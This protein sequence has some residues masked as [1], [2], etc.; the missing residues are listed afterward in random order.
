ME[1]PLHLEDIA[2]PSEKDSQ[3]AAQAARMLVSLLK[4]SKK[5]SPR[6]TIRPEGQDKSESVTVPREA[7]ALFVKILEQLAIGNAVTIVPIHAEL[8]TQQAADLLNVSRPY[9]IKLLEEGQ[10]PFH[11]VGT[12]RRIR[13]EA[14]LAYKRQDDA[15]R[16][17]ALRELTEEAEKHGLGY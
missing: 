2:T 13:F 4:G 11:K 12:H 9:L 17:A 1:T 6:V 7:L 10:L 15:R 16:Q 14:L 8:T 3:E 5:R